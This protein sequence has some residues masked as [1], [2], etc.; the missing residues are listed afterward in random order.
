MV[1]HKQLVSCQRSVFA[2]Q[3]DIS[4]ILERYRDSPFNS[5]VSFSQ[6]LTETVNAVDAGSSIIQA[7]VL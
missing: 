6:D 7:V 5:S 4:G 3:W 2:H 1:K